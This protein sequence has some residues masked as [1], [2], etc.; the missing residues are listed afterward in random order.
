MRTRLIVALIAVV[1]LVAVLL[2]VTSSRRGRVAANTVQARNAAQ[3][4]APV[5]AVPVVQQ[6]MPVYLKGLGTVTPY[7]MVT[8]HSRVDGEL[9]KVNFSE[10]Q[11]VKAGDLLAV[12]DPRPFEAQLHQAE[13]TT[14]R[15]QAQLNDAE[16]NL[17]RYQ[18]LYRQGIIAKQQLDTQ[19]ALV[20]QLKGAVD[21]DK[22][23]VENARLQVVYSRITAPISGRV[24]LRLVDPGNI[25]HATDTNGMLVITQL[26]PI[27]IIFTLPE[28]Y[29]PT[30]LKHM[31]EETLQALAYSRD[32]RTR[33]ATGRLLTLNNEIDTTTGTNRFKAIFENS[34]RM[35]WPN[36]FVNV[37]LLLDVKKNVLVIPAAAIQHGNQG[38][39][40]FVVKPDNTAE[41]RN[42]KVGITEGN[43][44]SIDEG[45][46]RGDM[47]VTDGQDKIQPGAK[48]VVQ[49]GNGRPQGNG[50]VQPSAS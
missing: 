35:L 20:G 15:D 49:P 1:V 43:R 36:Q 41:V 32:D 12:I 4:A 9:V 26:Q 33:I 18:D 31:K 47:V 19:S 50:A 17:A 23:Q 3:R 6:D 38:T 16:I 21:A 11:D 25:V 22:A 39:F 45:L 24:G 5:A 28:D 2:G 14:A 30:V 27:A 13:A 10:G 44:V 8:V 37:W 40:V 46:S 48:V 34:D 42:V 7:Y 29:V